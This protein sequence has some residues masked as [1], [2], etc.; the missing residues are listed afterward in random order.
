MKLQEN[1]ECFICSGRAVDPHHVRL[2]NCS[3]KK[4]EKYNLLIYL[5][6]PCHERLHRDEKMKRYIQRF[7][8]KKLEEEMSHD[9][10]MRIFKKNYLGDEY[11]I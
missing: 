2:G 7:A 3:R 8:Q 11:G 6:R 4:A 1:K 10:Y 5:C 9:E